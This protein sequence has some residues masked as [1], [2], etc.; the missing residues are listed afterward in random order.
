[1]AENE[2]G[3]L[4]GYRCKGDPEWNIVRLRGG[5]RHLVECKAP[6]GTGDEP[7]FESLPPIWDSIDRMVECKSAWDELVRSTVEEDGPEAAVALVVKLVER[8]GSEYDDRWTKAYEAMDPESQRKVL[9]AACGNLADVGAA[10]ITYIRLVAR[11]RVDTPAITAAAVRRFESMLE[12][13]DKISRASVWAAGLAIAGDPS[14]AGRI[15][16]DALP[17]A[18]LAGEERDDLALAAIAHAEAACPAVSEVLRS[19]QCDREYEC[20]GKLCTR[21]EAR[22]VV[23]DWVKSSVDQGQAK[24]PWP[25]PSSSRALLAAAYAIG[26]P[27]DFVR[28]N[29]RQRYQ[30]SKSTLPACDGALPNGAP[31][32]CT[33]LEPLALCEVDPGEKRARIRACS[34]RFNDARHRIEDVR[35]VCFEEGTEAP[36]DGVCCSGLERARADAGSYRCVRPPE[37]DAATGADSG[38]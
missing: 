22:K 34:F 20:E 16:C 7:A 32:R 29:A 21:E 17:D 37:P 2:A 31:C 24:Q 18:A 9:G 8:D 15:A 5:S 1:M 14:A 30:V 25:L 11:C 27:E 3:T 19:R 33:S 35:R 13:K 28:R 4:V 23:E 12:S 6:V 10:D 36:W 38:R 26:L